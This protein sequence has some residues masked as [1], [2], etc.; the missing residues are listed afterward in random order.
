MGGKELQVV[1]EERDLGVI[2][3]SDFKVSKQCEKAATASKGNQILGLINKT[4]TCKK[5]KII[6]NLSDLT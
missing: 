2:I 1:N 6:L 5:K 4:I 3:T